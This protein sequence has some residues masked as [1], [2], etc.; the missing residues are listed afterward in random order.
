MSTPAKPEV[1]DP[2]S[3]EY[4][5][6]R[7]LRDILADPPSIQPQVEA[8]APARQRRSFFDRRRRVDNGIS[9]EPFPESLRTFMRSDYRAVPRRL[10][11]KAALAIL[12][13]SVVAGGIA[14]VVY[15][16]GSK[17]AEPQDRSLLLKDAKASLAER[18]QAAS[19]ELDRRPVKVT[20]PTLGV[21]DQSGTINA[22]LPIGVDVANPTP[23]ATV[24]LGG[25]L[26]GTTLSAGAAS[27][28]G[29]WRVGVADLSKALMTPPRNYVGSMAIVAELQG[30]DGQVIVRSRVRYAWKQPVVETRERVDV[31]PAAAKPPAAVKAEAPKTDAPAATKAEA[32]PPT[33]QIDPAEVA[34]L[35]KR[36]EELLASGDLAAARLLLQRVA[37]THN[38]RAALELGATYDPIVIKQRGIFSAAPDPA[39][40]QAWYQRARDWGSVE[41]SKQ[42]E[43]LASSA[44]R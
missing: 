24:K 26:P 38:A 15:F 31:A 43:A 12:A 41:A 29:E 6:P 33:R 2:K 18:L 28:P 14:A 5:A 34:L 10:W 13:G 8:N 21:E 42:L 30:G 32:S 37:E 20:P 19:A 27:G 1:S 23:G 4:Y 11:R 35:L 36:S 25:L 3:P 44:R 40:A 17:L 22:P 16:D 7:N 9:T 39:L